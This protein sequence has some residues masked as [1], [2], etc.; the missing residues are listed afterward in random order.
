VRAL[1]GWTV[2]YAAGDADAPET[3]AKGTTTEETTATTATTVAATIRRRVWWFPP[4]LRGRPARA[5]PGTDT[6]EPFPASVALPDR[7]RS[8]RILRLRK[9]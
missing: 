9:G 6:R 2:D 5:P 1:D 4:R 8:R 7:S 3:T